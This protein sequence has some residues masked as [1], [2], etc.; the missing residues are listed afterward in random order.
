MQ[1]NLLSLNTG[2]LRLKNDIEQL[3]FDLKERDRDF[4]RR[5]EEHQRKLARILL[6]LEG[7]QSTRAAE[8]ATATTDATQVVA[9]RTSANGQ[10]REA[11]DSP[12]EFAAPRRMNYQP[13]LGLQDSARPL[14]PPVPQQFG[15]S[16]NANLQTWRRLELH[17]W[18]WDAK[19]DWDSNTTK[20]FGKLRNAILCLEEVKSQSN[21]TLDEAAE[22]LDEEQKRLKVNIT[23]HLA[24]KM[25][26]NNSIASRK[27]KKRPREPREGNNDV[28]GRA[29]NSKRRPQRARRV[30]GRLPAV[31]NLNRNAWGSG[32]T[33]ATTAVRAMSRKQTHSSGNRFFSPAGPMAASTSVA[34]AALKTTTNK[35]SGVDILRR[36]L[37][38]EAFR[39]HKRDEILQNQDSRKPAAIPRKRPARK[40]ERGTIGLCSID[41]CNKPNVN[42]DHHCVNP[43]CTP[44]GIHHTCAYDYKLH[45]YN[46]MKCYCCEDCKEHGIAIG[47]T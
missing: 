17:K 46:E 37:E 32:G 4:L 19:K 9:V 41:G 6:L 1:D 30:G 29:D 20:R 2:N 24:A 8:A 44:N 26:E 5:D 7:Q 40:A 45:L 23:T 10:R 25:K 21:G 33:V 36:T 15:K 31:Q 35:V 34:R 27:R 11:N 47:H 43:D 28:G 3:K 14:Q 22:F 39:R 12:A 16:W 38:I 13:M 18:S 42:I